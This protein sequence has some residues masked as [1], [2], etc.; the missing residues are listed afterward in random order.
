MKSS[1]LVATARIVVLTTMATWPLL[2][3]AQEA[4]MAPKAQARP[5]FRWAFERHPDSP[6]LRARPGRWDA[7]WFTIGAVLR[8][9]DRYRMYFCGAREGD[10]KTSSLGLAVSDDG[11]R[12]R[13]H[14]DE[15]IWPYRQWDHFLRDVR[16]HQLGPTDFWLYY[17][18]GDRHIDLARSADGIRWTHDPRTPILRPSQPWEHFVMQQRIL[19]LGEAWHMWYSTYG[20]KPRVTGYATS[21]DGVRW[22]KYAQNPV[23]PLG[24]P[25]EWDDFSAFQPFVFRQDGLF[26]MIY[27]GSSTR[28]KTGY[29]W[30]HAWSRDGVHW[31]KSPDNPVFLPGEK[32]AWDAGKV[33]CPTLVRTGPDAFNVYYCGAAAPGATYLGI[34]LARARL[35]KLGDAP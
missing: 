30:G 8:V 7:A 19:K 24:K 26:H 34:G 9:D 11:V 6:V 17:S 16:V 5:S 12:W 1:R 28:N 31:T 27:N 14:Q 32:G 13:R 21:E 23:L 2:A 3:Q 35:R 15:P 20:P 4:A 33:S 25:G 10:N 22:T 29:R 18:D